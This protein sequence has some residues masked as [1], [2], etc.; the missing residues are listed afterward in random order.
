MHISIVLP[1][2]P[3]WADLTLWTLRSY[4]QQTSKNFEILLVEDGEPSRAILDL[5]LMPW[6][7]PIRYYNSPRVLD[8]SLAHKNHARNVGIKNASHEV[9][10]VCDC[11]FLVQPNFIERVTAL[12]HQAQGTAYRFCLYPPCAILTT[13]P[14]DINHVDWSHE[15]DP[16]LIDYKSHPDRNPS[17]RPIQAHPEGMHIMDRRLFEML[18][19]YDEDFLGWCANKMELQRRIN[20]AAIKQFL[21][22]GCLLFHQPHPEL[23]SGD[24]H[25][26]PD[27]KRKNLDLM[28]AKGRNRLDCPDWQKRKTLISLPPQTKIP[29]TWLLSWFSERIPASTLSEDPLSQQIR[30]TILRA[31]DPTAP[32]VLFGPWIG[33][34][35]WE[36]CRWQGGVRKMA[37]MHDGYTI[38]VCGDP[39]HAPLYPYAHEYW[40]LPRGLYEQVLTRESH[41]LIPDQPARMAM[42]AVRGV[43]AEEIIQR[44]C[45]VAH[46]PASHNNTRAFAS[47]PKE[48][49]TLIPIVADDS[50]QAFGRFVAPSDR[51]V[52][53]FPRSRKLNPHKNWSAENWLYL[54]DWLHTKH[55]LSSVVLGRPE[56]TH[57]L[58]LS[59]RPHATSTL[60]LQQDRRLAI[61]IALL[62]GAVASIGSE[63]GGPFLA[64][65]C[66]C[67]S[68]V[69]GGP[70][71]RQRYTVDENPL[72]TDCF[73]IESENFQH[74]LDSICEEFDSWFP[75]IKTEPVSHPVP[76]RYL[77]PAPT[78]PV[79][80]NPS[81]LSILERIERLERELGI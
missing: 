52:C 36:I 60:S 63:C 67:P 4:D 31:S 5:A 14:H 76:I 66:G 27:I 59:E 48:S 18:G 61:N 74:S 35:G 16:F 79:P 65:M 12:Y 1:T 24:N 13:P 46:V 29:D 47:Q 43:L 26:S 45:N 21:L 8:A 37:S 54:I 71:W 55:R 34:F 42:S 38:I 2:A 72:R 53:L 32:I 68:M 39:G 15:F 40:S 11:D 6:S 77:D 50:S 49:Q 25:K 9:I 58:D 64:M 78:N 7:F 57:N 56:D 23:H 10:F 3:N 80:A 70:Q 30:R 73:Y 62:N 75:K 81:N 41:R 19:F 28:E 51:Y 20:D 33:E 69:M 22:D 44:G 17:L